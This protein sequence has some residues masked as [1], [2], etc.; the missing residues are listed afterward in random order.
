MPKKAFWLVLIL[1]IGTHP[2]AA[3][4][5]KYDQLSQEARDLIQ[6]IGERCK[7][8]GNEEDWVPPVSLPTID[9]DGNGSQDIFLATRDIC[10]GMVPAGNCSNRGAILIVRRSHWSLAPI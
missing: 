3:Q 4:S 10:R 7:E 8:Y 9:L 2:T 1:L 5:I 6:D